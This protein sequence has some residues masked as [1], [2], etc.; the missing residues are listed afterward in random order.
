MP[1]PPAAMR[2]RV[3]F[4]LPSMNRV[5]RVRVAGRKDEKGGDW[6]RV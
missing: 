1:S 6:R 5:T 4:L 3:E 2:L